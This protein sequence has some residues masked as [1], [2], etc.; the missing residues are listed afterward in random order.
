MQRAGGSWCAVAMLGLVAWLLPA[1]A[2]TA[3]AEPPAVMRGL[4]AALDPAGQPWSVWSLDDGANTELWSS[5]WTEHGWET[6]R[7]VS[8]NPQA[9]DDSPSL[10][11]AA[12]GT[13]WVAWTSGDQNLGYLLVSRWLGKRWSTPERVPI[14]PASQ[15]QLPSLAAAPDGE[16]WLA[17][18]GFD[19]TDDEIYASRRQGSTWSAPER[20]GADDTEYDTR[21]RLAVAPDGR[22]WLVWVSNRGLFDDAIIASYWEGAAWSPEMA[23]SAE[24]NSP[25]IAPALALDGHGNPWVA[26]QDVTSREIDGLRR[27]YLAHWDPDRRA[28]SPEQNVSSPLSLAVDEERPSL[29]SDADGRLH[30]AWSVSG[31]LE[32]TAYSM[33]VP[34]AKEA[35][36]APP[37]WLATGDAVEAPIVL[38]GEELRF[39]WSAPSL[40]G[41]PE[42][43]LPVAEQL[44][45]KPERLPETL[46][47]PAP[48]MPQQSALIPNRHLA[49]GDSITEGNYTDVSGEPVIPYP[50]ALEALLD[51]NVVDSEVINRGDSGEKLKPGRDRVCSELNLYLPEFLL[52]ME[53]TNDVSLD[54]TTCGDIAARFD[55]L[56]K[57]I[58]KQCNVKGV[59]TV[60]STLVPRL[61]RLNRKTEECNADI[62]AVAQSWGMPVADTWSDFIAYGDYG[63]LYRDLLHP[64]SAGLALIAHSFYD[65][66]LATGWLPEDTAPPTAQIV[67]LPAQS[68]CGAVVVSWAGDDGAGSGIADFDVQVQ[69]DGGPWTDWLVATA[70]SSGTYMR[71]SP[72]DSLGFRVRARD[73]LG[74]LGGYSSPATTHIVDTQPPYADG[75]APLPPVRSRSFAVSWWGRDACGPIAAYDVEYRIG[76]GLWQRWLT[77]AP[78]PGA[79]FDPTA[80][81]CGRT[82]AFRIVAYDAAGNRSRPDDIW[83][84]AAST[85]V[86][87]DTVSGQ[88]RTI[89]E[90]PILQAQASASPPAVGAD[91][92]DGRGVYS[93]YFAAIGDYD[94]SVER[95]GFGALPPRRAV[96]VAESI[97]GVDFYLPPL[98]DLV[99]NGGFEESDWGDWQPLGTTLP[100]L[101]GVA[102][103][104]DGATL[105]DPG[106]GDSRLRQELAVPGAMA[107][108]TLSLLARTAGD[109]F[110]QVGTSRPSSGSTL[111]VT[112]SGASTETHPI[113]VPGQAGGWIHAWFDLAAFAG[114]SISLT[115]RVVGDPAVIVDEVS[116]G[117]A[118]A[119][120]HPV[121]LPLISASYRSAYQAD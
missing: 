112:I 39:F 99:G 33:V 74:N 52:L 91:P 61:D 28:W 31:V 34:G 96:A 22:A 66:L 2:S 17:W 116:L 26:W 111:T 102:H 18:V 43:A 56:L 121:Y 83:S 105:L 88:V 30:L 100:V 77:Q 109:A 20:V 16:L 49:F 6:P 25:D 85:T 108:P 23:V 84:D 13:P 79:I 7:P 3:Q 8:V 47:L 59:K 117:S 103:T 101:T 48:A 57:V 118:M 119:G 73:R 70:D 19:G 5:R 76:N 36:W 114:Q 65:T 14:D 115:L 113:D 37:V 11:F 35:K 4:G 60:V 55:L 71:G 72:G 24:D 95:A 32:G 92:S 120:A 69:H 42:A 68:E 27:I 9:W 53:G 97:A 51:S 45:A 50:V 29:A 80:I 106:G 67:E 82:Y 110:E 98:D 62:T 46:E 78:D 21:P 40:A 10:A 54:E 58:R 63:D 107:N 41:G 89:R 94:I 44:A 64:G 38:A 15:P 104:G 81:Q 90:M 12:D 93:L 1:P 75:V 86:V 87:C